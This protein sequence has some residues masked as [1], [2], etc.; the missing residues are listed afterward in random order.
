MRVLI[1]SQYYY[2]EGVPKPHELAEEL[3]ERGHDVSVLTGFPHY[4]GG[5]LKNGYKLSLWLR[6]KINNIKVL[7]TFELPYHNTNAILRMANY[8]SFLISAPFGAFFTPKVDV[9]YVWH[10]PL[11]I[12]IA[13][14]LIAK[15]K[16][17]PF[18]YDVQDIWPDF[19]IL[20]GMMRENSFSVKVLRILEA[21]VYRRANH[22]IVGTE[23]ARE[24]LVGKLVPCEKLTVLPNWIDE[25]AFET[26]GLNERESL[27]DEFGWNNSFV[28]LFAGNHGIIQGLE[29]VIEAAKYLENDSTKIVLVGDG[30]DKPRLEKLARELQVTDKVQFIERQPMEKMP[31]FMSAADVLLV[32]LKK[33]EMQRYVIPSK[34]IAYLASGKPILMAMNGAAAELIDEAKAGI[35]IE[36]DDPRQLAKAIEIL[37]ETSGTEKADFGAN[38]RSYLLQNLS[39]KQ[40]VARYEKLLMK[41][42]ENAKE[43]LKPV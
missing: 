35:V 9:I 13:A 2:P 41:V 19:V 34:T 4:P 20:S 39:K 6:E 36:P 31:D 37:T 42:V 18:V 32:H 5:K 40:V 30:S 33:S 16:G 14:W 12:G 17:V 25:T 29:T 24:N 15:I 22:L 8:L 23:A 26:N 38:G 7:R 27:R 28:V 43:N 10:P 3:V 1:L 21:F 11:T